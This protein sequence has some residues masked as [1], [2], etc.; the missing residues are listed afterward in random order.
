MNLSGEAESVLQVE[1]MVELAE[2]A[3]KERITSVQP[4]ILD[5]VNRLYCEPK[6]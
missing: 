6:P 5:A 4:K 1:I 3:D 2:E